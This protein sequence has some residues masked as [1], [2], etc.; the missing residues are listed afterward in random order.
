VMRLLEK[1]EA[2]PLAA[3]QVYRAPLESLGSPT[4]QGWQRVRAQIGWIGRK[5]L[6][7]APV[8]QSASPEPAT[9]P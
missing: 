1:P 4:P 3:A 2:D 9:K 8:I 7:V 6:D 5:D